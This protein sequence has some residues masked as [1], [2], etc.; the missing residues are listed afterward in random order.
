MPETHALQTYET[1]P[2]GLQLCSVITRRTLKTQAP[3][4]R[5]A[6]VTRHTW[7]SVCAPDAT[8]SLTFRS[9]TAAQ[10]QMIIDALLRWAFGPLNSPERAGAGAGVVALVMKIEAR[11]AR[12]FTDQDRSLYLSG[13][14][15]PQSARAAG[16][17]RPGFE[18][19]GVFCLG[20]PDL[21]EDPATQPEDP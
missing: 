12:C 19:S 11:N 6:R 21:S 13:R 15:P 17:G 8:A 5:P 1:S 3:Q 9:L 10:W 18:Q 20:K 14:L 4:S 2:V 16:Q 7:A